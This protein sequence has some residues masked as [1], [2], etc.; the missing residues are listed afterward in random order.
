MN[1]KNMDLVN[2]HKRFFPP[3]KSVFIRLHSDSVDKDFDLKNE[4]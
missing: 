3:K 2:L 4:I 1:K